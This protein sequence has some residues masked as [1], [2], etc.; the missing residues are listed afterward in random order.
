[1]AVNGSLVACAVVHDD[2]PMLFLAEDLDVLHRTLALELVAG[3][4][5]TRVPEAEG[6][7]LREALLD[8][9]WGDAVVEW[10]GRTGI[11]VDVYTERV[12]TAGDVPEDLIGAQIQ[13]APL[14]REG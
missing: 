3:T 5:A 2:P 11:A 7:A 4:D 14:F 1:M 9:R 12:A 10:M 6:E 13:F 8:E